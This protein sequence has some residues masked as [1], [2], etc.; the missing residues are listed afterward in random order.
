MS[1]AIS[2]GYNWKELT[3]SVHEDGSEIDPFVDPQGQVEDLDITEQSAELADFGPVRS[4]FHVRTLTIAAMFKNERRWIRE[5][6]EFY[7]MMGAEHFILYD[8]DSTDHP[9]EI[10]QYYIDQGNV[11]YI[12]WPPER[13]PAPEPFKTQFEKSQYSLFTEFLEAC[14]SG[15]ETIHKH[16]PCQQAAFSDAIRRTKG[17]VSRW[18]G[19]FDIDEYI[20]PR[21]TSKFRSLPEVLRERHADTDHI[22][23]GGSH[24]GTSGHVDHAALRKEGSPL[25]AL[26][27][28]SYTYRAEVDA[29][30]FGVGW[31]SSF[32]KALADPDMVSHSEIHRFAPPANLVFSF[33]SSTE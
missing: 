29:P 20:F 21:P 25:Q 18:L 31:S 30:D 19:L 2:S 14:F 24:F 26:R 27:T 16:A 8:H 12:P 3:I 28:E 23:V 5:W 7:T 15:A 10:L 32:T 6:I 13:I 22:V 9:L 17:G 4:T 11:T 1:G 33:S